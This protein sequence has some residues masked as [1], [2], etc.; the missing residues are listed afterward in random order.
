MIARKNDGKY[1]HAAWNTRRADANH[2][3]DGRASYSLNWTDDELRREWAHD[4]VDL[5]A[6]HLTTLE[7][8]ELEQH[9]T[10][11]E[12]GLQT[13]YEVGLALLAIRA[14]R[15][16]R[17]THPTFEDYCR[18]KWGW[19][20]NYANKLISASEIVS[21]LMGTGVPIPTSEGHVR[22]LKQLSTDEQ[23]GAWQQ[24]VETAPDGKI[25]EA[26]VARVVA[27]RKRALA[28]F[29]EHLQ[30]AIAEIAAAQAATLQ[31]ELSDRLIER[32]GEIIVDA[33][34]NGCVDTGDGK[35]TPLIAALTHQ[36]TEAH[37]RNAQYNHEWAQRQKSGAITIAAGRITA[38]NMTAEE[39]VELLKA[40]L[41]IVGQ[42]TGDLPRKVSLND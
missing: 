23:P 14:K 15:L 16:Y 27:E 19:G 32:T 37:K 17:E 29:P 26:H 42:M 39:A 28:Q 25:T 20:R 7:R 35:S 36:Q 24:A 3:A 34:I 33:S 2:N 41:E 22:P 5:P 10:V 18:D 4:S 21:R 11:I 30:P 40:A 12:R 13:F 1:T 8:F 31:T 9:E 6:D 38:R